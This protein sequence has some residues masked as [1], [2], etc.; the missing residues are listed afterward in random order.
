MKE[1]NKKY[2]A[3]DRPR[4]LSPS[5]KDVAVY[6]S[7]L[8]EG[9]VLLLGCTRQL[10]P[11]SDFQMDIDPWYNG[12]NVIIQDWVTN[13]KFYPNIMI[14]GGLCFTK[15]LCDG[16]LRMAS[17]NCTR[18]ISRSFTH[19]LEI[20]IIADYFPKPTDFNIYPTWIRDEFSKDYTFYIWE[21]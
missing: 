4:P 19:K 1:A 10:L 20:M 16:I 8:V 17:Q 3:S 5:D 6:R 12:P 11:L 7:Y 15:E 13:K 14:D 9:E 21:F 2:W 18:L